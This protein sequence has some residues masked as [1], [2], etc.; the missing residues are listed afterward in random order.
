MVISYRAYLLCWFRFLPA[1]QR[2]CVH[3][4]RRRGK[5]EPSE[6]QA[7]S[8]RRRRHRQALLHPY[9]APLGRLEKCQHCF[10]KAIASLTAWSSSSRSESSSSSSSGVLGRARG[11]LGPVLFPGVSLIRTLLQGRRL[12]ASLGRPGPRLRPW[13]PQGARL[14]SLVGFA[15]PCTSRRVCRRPPPTAV[16]GAPPL[17]RLAAAGRA[18]RS[19]IGPGGPWRP[20]AARGA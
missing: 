19:A 3:L 13:G 1:G 16:G 11:V 14:G 8:Q 9:R 10:S 17:G 20:T 18:S 6:P 5:G 12:K 7:R 15:M 2:Q 4:A